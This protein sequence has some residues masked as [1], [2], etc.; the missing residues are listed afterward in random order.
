MASRR[1]LSEMPL[2]SFAAAGMI[3]V[4]L[5]RVLSGLTSIASISESNAAL[6]AVASLF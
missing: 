5:A 1:A 4:L 2:K 6:I 3:E